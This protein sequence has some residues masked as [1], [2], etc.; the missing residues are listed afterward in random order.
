MTCHN[1]FM[2]ALQQTG[3]LGR[4]IEAA[5]AA[6]H[7]TTINSLL[8][9]PHPPSHSSHHLLQHLA[10]RASSAKIPLAHL[11]RAPPCCYSW[12]LPLQRSGTCSTVLQ[13]G[14][15]AGQLPQLG[16]PAMSEQGLGGPQVGMGGPSPRRTRGGGPCTPCR[17]CGRLWDRPLTSGHRLQPCWLRSM[18]M[19]W[20]LQLQHLLRLRRRRPRPLQQQPEG[21]QASSPSA[22]RLQL[23]A[24]FKHSPPVQ[25][26]T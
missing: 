13:A 10:G 2:R 14:Q 3:P 15:L 18:R 5:L 24:C 17:P 16:G 21:Q 1:L 8:H 11:P 23:S 4:G 12:Q 22:S 9:A 7:I 20:G 25:Q 6:C 19:C 26:A